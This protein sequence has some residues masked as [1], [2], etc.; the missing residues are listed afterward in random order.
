MVGT[1]R[2]RRDSEGARS[3]RGPRSATANRRA[4][5]V[6]VRGRKRGGADQAQGET[7]ARNRAILVLG[8]LGLLNAYVFTCSGLPEVG[9]QPA[10]IHR[11]RGPLPPLGDPVE[12]ACTSDP[13]RIF[14]GL[15]DLVMLD[16][17]LRGGQTVHGAL[18]A[19]GVP[20]SEV[21]K[22]EGALQPKVDL[23]LM[24]GTGA[25]IRVALDRVGA[26]HA[27]EIERNE[28]RLLQACRQGEGFTVRTIEQPLRTDVEVIAFELGRD[29]DLRAAVLRAGEKPELAVRLA[30]VLAHE[31]DFLTEAR[32]GDKVQVIVE[33]RWL[34]NRFHRYGAV[35]AVRLRGSVRRATL[36]RYK[37]EGREEAYFDEDGESARRSLLR[38]PIRYFGVDWEARALLAPSVEVA[39][40]RLGAA[41]RL[42]EGAAIVA[43]GDGT[44]RAADRTIDDGNFVDLEL[45][46]GTMVRYSHLMRFLGPMRSGQRVHQGQTIGLAGHTGR[47]P[48]DRL[49]LELW[50][51]TAG[52]VGSLD[53]LMLTAKGE[54]RSNRVGEPIPERQKAR[55]EQ[56][57][58]PQ[59]QAIARAR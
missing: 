19:L 56:D 26:V 18:L 39:R 15:H 16:G 3:R 17:S 24:G 50:S 52:V 47:T 2:K 45:N 31:I 59:R 33:K 9:L 41:Y 53:P 21:D 48:H 57:T 13:V 1:Q 36:Y 42:P 10:A 23:G 4:S 34:G 46:D 44:I 30:E 20:E 8:G 43:L 6:K 40:G 32:P 7:R 51:E 5:E 29:A 14:E 58:A 35:L 37:P 54:H 55:F 22:V 12:D 25:P 27:L 11:A 49:R 28:G 38:S